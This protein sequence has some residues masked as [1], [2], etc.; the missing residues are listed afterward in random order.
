MK[1]ITVTYIDYDETGIGYSAKRI[2]ANHIVSYRKTSEKD[3]TTIQMS[4]GPS[5]EVKEGLSHIDVAIKDLESRTS[6]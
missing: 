1:F 3:T 6:K 4:A 5:F 2:A